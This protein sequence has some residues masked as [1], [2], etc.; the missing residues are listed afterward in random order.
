MKKGTIET[1]LIIVVIMA[2]MIAIGSNSVT[3]ESA[4]AGE[5]ERVA[6]QKP[7]E[8]KG[9]VRDVKTR[10]GKTITVAE[11]HPQGQSQS[12]ISVAFS[13][14]AA[15]EMKF[16][17]KDPISKVLVGDLDAN[18]FDEIYIITVS[19]GS[20]SY[21]NVIGLASLA[22][23][24][25]SPITVP[26]VEEKD[27]KAGGQFEGYT[28]HDEFEIIELSLA[29]RFP[30][31]AANATMRGINYKLKAGEAGFVLYI[32]NSTAY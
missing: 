31:K 11:T 25:L 5:P 20:G 3:N 8:N 22:D 14:N 7:Q 17:D 27:M 24:S 32:K 6:G 1:A 19:A 23:K 28:G 4:A 15:S 29:R 12:N 2:F 10:T 18:G 30:I 16:T 9:V 21:G 26:A 13:G